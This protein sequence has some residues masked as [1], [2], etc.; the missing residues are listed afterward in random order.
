MDESNSTTVVREKRRQPEEAGA[1]R[2]QARKAGPVSGSGGFFHQYKPEQGKNTRTGTIVAAG[3][4]IVW[5]AYFI[6]DRLQVYEGDEW[7]RLLITTGIP[8]A[9]AT[10]FGAFAWR[11][12]FAHPKMGDFMIAT[13]GEMKKVNWSSRKEIIGSTKVVILFTLL[14]AMFLF[15]VDLGF[16]KFFQIIGILKG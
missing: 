8:L 13:E 6:W 3:A 9:F 7:W 11:Y 2:Q 12:S 15:S 16:Q 14:M 4:L 1:V 10:L 5:G